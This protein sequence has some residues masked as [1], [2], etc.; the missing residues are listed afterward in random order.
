MNFALFLHFVTGSFVTNVSSIMTSSNNFDGLAR[1]PIAHTCTGLLEVSS[2]YNIF[3]Y[4]ESEFRAVLSD[5]Y[6]SWRMDAI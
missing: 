6:F 5:P 2:T 1:R 4:F 3:F